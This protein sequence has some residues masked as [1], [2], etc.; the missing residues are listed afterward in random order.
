MVLG[1]PSSIA[2]PPPRYGR[3][4]LSAVRLL[5][6]FPNDGPTWLLSSMSAISRLPC[7]T[8]KSQNLVGRN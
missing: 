1:I 6:V 8:S 7:M 2:Q 4:S 5:M 3:R